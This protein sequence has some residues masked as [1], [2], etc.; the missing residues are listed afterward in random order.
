[1]ADEI[2]KGKKKKK[3][4][5]W[6]VILV[7]VAVVFGG[8]R[9]A[10]QNAQKAAYTE[11]V[12]TKRDIQNAHNFTGTVAP[13][14]ESD[15]YSTVTGVRVKEVK[16]KKG[17]E[18]KKGDVIA[19]LDSSD[20]ESQIAQNEA[21]L[22]K[23]QE[24]NAESVESAQ[25]ALDNAKSNAASGLD[26]SVQSA[27]SS[28]TSAQKS[29]DDAKS[30]VEDG[31]DSSLLSAKTS[32]DNAADQYNNLKYNI[33]NNL[34]STLQSAQY[35]M[36][37]A[38]QQLLTAQENYNNEVKLNNQHLSST[39]LAA[40]QQVDS[41][42]Q[43]IV[44]A[45]NQVA[46]AQNSLQKYDESEASE[47]NEKTDTIR[48]GYV[49]SVDSA[50]DALS[51]AWQTYQNAQDSYKAAKINEENN[52]T[53]LYDTLLSA[54]DAYLHAV[55][56]YNATVNSLV[57]QLNQYQTAY[58]QAQTAYDAAVKAANQQLGTLK[59]TLDSAKSSYA[60]AVNSQSQ[61]IE[62]YQ[63][64]LDQAKTSSDT[65]TSELQIEQ[66][67][68][69]LAEYTLTAPMDGEITALNVEEGDLISGTTAAATV[70]SFD[71]MKINIKIG[72]YDIVST[73]EGGKVSVT[74]DAVDGKTYEGTIVYV[75]RTATVDNGV[76][77][78]ESEVDFDAD[79]DV[80][81]GMSAE[82]KLTVQEKKDAIS[83]RSDAVQTADD[84]TN[85]VLVYGDNGRDLV[86]KTVTCGISDGTY[87][88]ITDGLSEGDKVYYIPTSAAQSLMD[89]EMDA[90]VDEE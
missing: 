44:S 87:T 73:G 81:S 32:L 3:W 15:V 12:A 58:A 69:N 42:Y 57:Q 20:V 45:Q 43:S 25:E 1:M 2:K 72:E 63:N 18:V 59:N 38:Y 10:G 55:D 50:N 76:S 24:A 22:K 9:I 26:S 67:K 40:M 88:E 37:T 68:D 52:L 21:T 39:T 70:T 34:D 90:T 82:V 65:T 75:A 53:T 62:T 74:L 8:L 13:V 60:A 49:L 27:K 78:F 19:V 89:A 48:N 4:V 79:D 36:T 80:R 66:Q 51:A 30:N 77:Y 41:A 54:Q 85:Y 86:Q 29:Y 23:T 35:Q 56:S 14:N 16:V 31:T 83:I 64:Q 84:G 7:I 47:L 11:D 5:K 46:T 6:V 28:L 61:Q 33:E 71:K 17:D